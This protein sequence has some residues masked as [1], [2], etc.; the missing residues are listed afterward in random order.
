MNSKK[1]FYILSGTITLFII[2]TVLGAYELTGLLQ[3][4]ANALTN[5]KAKNLS[6]QNE[7]TELNQSKKDIVKY[8][9]LYQISQSVVPQNKDQTQAVRQIT[10]LATASG[11]NIESI[12][13]PSSTLGALPGAASAP[14]QA[15][16]SQAG[17]A[18]TGN[19]PNLSQLLKV[20]NI[21]GVYEL[22]LTVKSSSNNLATFQ[23]LTSYL[24]ALEQNRLTALVS[25]ITIQPSTTTGSQTPQNQ[26]KLQFT[27]VLD[28][29]INPKSK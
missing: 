7:Q 28:I 3:K 29:F 18:A 11:V 15:T 14:P 16:P 1:L 20:P 25:S 12:T 4:K 17:V 22:Q 27:L 10:N 6:L 5:D 8:Q 21:P 24:H 13:F 26:V 23:E 19:N 9:S 2:L